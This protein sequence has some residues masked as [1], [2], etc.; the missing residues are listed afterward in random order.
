MTP[1][2]TAHYQTAATETAGPAQLVLMLYDG[3]LARI[4]AGEEAL[5][6]T[7]VDRTATN[8]NLGRAQAIVHEL[9]VTLDTDRGGEVAANLVR[10]YE[11][12]FDQLVQAN[13]RKEPTPLAAVTEVLT[14]LRDAWERSCVDGHLTPVR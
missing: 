5:R 4:A 14:G 12:C 2:L 6:A 7:P 13:I 9:L 3:A 8:E 10:L 11:F 1:N